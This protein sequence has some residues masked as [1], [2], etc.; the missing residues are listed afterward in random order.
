MYSVVCFLFIALVS[1]VLELLGRNIYHF[2]WLAVFCYVLEIVLSLQS[3][4]V[5]KCYKI[6]CGFSGGYAYAF[7]NAFPIVTKSWNTWLYFQ[8]SD[9]TV[10]CLK[11]TIL[12]RMPW[13][14]SQ[15]AHSSPASIANHFMLKLQ[16]HHMSWERGGWSGWFPGSYAADTWFSCSLKYK[17]FTKHS[18]G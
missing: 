13:A 18:F 5:Y 4:F 6:A 3:Y 2:Y 11:G 12:W 15:G 17:S 10:R 8:R 16:F 14:E 1:K 7:R 9:L